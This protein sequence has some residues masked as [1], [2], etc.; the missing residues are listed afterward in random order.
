MKNSLRFVLVL[1][2]V[3]ISLI[4]HNSACISSAENNAI[5]ARVDDIV[6]RNEEGRLLKNFY[7]VDLN[8][9]VSQFVKDAPALGKAFELELIPSQRIIDFV[10]A[11]FLKIAHAII[12]ASKLPRGNP[13]DAAWKQVLSGLFMAWA[14]V[15][16]ELLAGKE[17]EIK[18]GWFQNIPLMG[19]KKRRELIQSLQDSK[20]PEV[21]PYFL[22]QDS[23]ES[24]M[25]VLEI[26]QGSHILVIVV[27]ELM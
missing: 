12:E 15:F 9:K 13:E 4:S 10:V 24:K 25:I 16:L 14:R 11:P 22:E 26:R 23:C 19:I 18:S 17:F 27:T 6:A 20:F 3:S 8:A 1:V 7:I 5:L 2:R 21:R